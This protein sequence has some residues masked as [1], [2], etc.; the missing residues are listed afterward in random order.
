MFWSLTW[1]TNIY[2]SLNVFIQIILRKHRT[3]KSFI[4]DAFGNGI[5]DFL[6]CFIK[7]GE[8]GLMSKKNKIIF[9]NNYWDQFNL[10]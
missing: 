9:I 3:L 8:L 2:I 4:L 6:V 5:L 1:Y 10:I 7:I